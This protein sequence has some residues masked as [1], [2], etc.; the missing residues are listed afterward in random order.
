M[1]LRP[2]VTES[3]SHRNIVQSGFEEM[4]TADLEYNLSG[5][6]LGYGG[7]LKQIGEL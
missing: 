7:C 3:H 2:P 1:V 4:S 5:N 6:L